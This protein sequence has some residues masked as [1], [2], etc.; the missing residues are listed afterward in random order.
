MLFL[1]EFLD[2]IWFTLKTFL[3]LKHLAFSYFILIFFYQKVYNHYSGVRKESALPLFVY[4]RETRRKGRRIEGRE[5][6]GF[7]YFLLKH[8]KG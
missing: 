7:I 1:R 4:K 5:G 8:I 2:P 6:E 3:H